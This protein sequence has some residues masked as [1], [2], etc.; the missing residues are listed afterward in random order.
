MFKG[1]KKLFMGEDFYLSETR[2]CCNL[3]KRAYNEGN[4]SLAYEYANQAMEALRKHTL[5]EL[6]LFSMAIEMN[7]PPQPLYFK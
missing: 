4:L 1:I 6:I 7:N 2:K 5:G 3:G